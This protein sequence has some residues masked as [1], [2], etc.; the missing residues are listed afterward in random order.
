MKKPLIGITT[1]GRDEEDR[2]T[3][4]AKYVD[5][6]RRAGGTAILLAPGGQDV[7]HWLD[8]VD[9]LVLAGGGDI[10][11]QLYGGV[12]HESVYMVDGERDGSE[13]EL[14][15]RILASGLP[16]LAICRGA[17][18]VNVALGGTLH[19]HLPDVFGD[20]VKHRLP[21]REPTPHDVRL[22]DGSSLARIIGALEFSC[23]SWHHQAIRDV[24]P[25]LKVVGYAPDGVVEAVEKPDH[26]WLHGV[27]W[28]PELTAAEDPLEQ[29]LFDAHVEASR[30]RR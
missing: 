8:V 5:A 7:D 18:I 12:G 13:L 28:H 19:E 23:E 25:T 2:F 16:T 1:Y 27:Q 22:D 4:P 26:P 15:R 10:D 6:V 21:P 9:G 3:L 24:A 14:A 20:D 29:R 30:R 11:P 17:Q